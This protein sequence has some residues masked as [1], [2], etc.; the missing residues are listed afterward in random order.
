MHQ[1]HKCRDK[2]MKPEENVGINLC[3][4]GSGNG[5]LGLIQKAQAIKKKRNIRPH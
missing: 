2:A 3:N 5:F 1:R 4:F